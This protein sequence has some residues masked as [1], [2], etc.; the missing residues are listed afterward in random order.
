MAMVR[1]GSKGGRL[2]KCETSENHHVLLAALSFP[3]NWPVVALRGDGVA[4]AGE[5]R[6]LAGAG[7]AEPRQL[8]ECLRAAAALSCKLAT[9]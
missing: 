2:K 1:Y 8:L 6:R 5:E 7:D 9:N 4:G 3:T